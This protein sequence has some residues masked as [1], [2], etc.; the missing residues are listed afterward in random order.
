MQAFKYSNIFY[1]PPQD[2]LEKESAVRFEMIQPFMATSLQRTKNVDRN[3]VGLSTDIFSPFANHLTKF[4]TGDALDKDVDAFCKEYG[5][6]LLQSFS[7]RRP[8]QRSPEASSENVEEV[9]E[10]SV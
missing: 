2:P 10:P 6:L 4:L 3:F 5:D 8:V 7:A 9:R 1:L